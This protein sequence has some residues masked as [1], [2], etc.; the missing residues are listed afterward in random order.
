MTQRMKDV[1]Q[2]A[3][4]KHKASFKGPEEPFVAGNRARRGRGGLCIQHRD[5]CGGEILGGAVDGADGDDGAAAVQH[6][7]H[8]LKLPIAHAV[9]PA[10][11]VESCGNAYKE[12]HRYSSAAFMKDWPS[13]YG[14]VPTLLPA[15]LATPTAVKTPITASRLRKVVMTRVGWSGDW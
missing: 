6:H 5:G 3:V 7:Q 4:S 15:T 12:G 1:K 11:S 9:A 8:T 13:W 2:D 10:V 14:A